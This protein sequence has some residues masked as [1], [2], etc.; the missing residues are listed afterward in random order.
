MIRENLIMKTYN[1]AELNSIQA[2]WMALKHDAPQAEQ[3]R[4]FSLME[5]MPKNYISVQEDGNAI[6]MWANQPL[7][8]AM[9]ISDVLEYHGANMDSVEIAW[10]CPNWINL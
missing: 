5:K 4:V 9:P 3:E 7:N 2:E 8:M 6:A 1:I 10:K